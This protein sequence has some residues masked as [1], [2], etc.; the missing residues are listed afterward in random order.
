MWKERIKISFEGIYSSVSKL[1][2]SLILPFEVAQW[3]GHGASMLEI[4]SSK[5]LARESNWFAICVKLVASDLP[6]VG[7]LSCVVCEL[8][9]IIVA[10]PL[11]IKRKNYDRI[12]ITC[13]FR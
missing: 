3:F 12:V 9:H 4:S 7:Y 6:S 5:P 13:E 1:N 10:V 8:S 11:V 2:I